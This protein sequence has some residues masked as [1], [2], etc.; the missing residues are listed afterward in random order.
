VE[1]FAALIKP[2]GAVL[3]FACGHGR[4][5]AYLAACGF[6]VDAV[7][8]DASALAPLSTLANVA[9]RCADLESGPWP[10]HGARFDGVI[11]TSYLYR[12]R[13]AELLALVAEEGVLIYETFMAGHEAFGKPSNPDFLLQPDELLDRV[14]GT[15]K[16]VAFEQGRI[17]ANG[18]MVIQRVCAVRGPVKDRALCA[19]ET[20]Q[21]AS[22]LS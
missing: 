6:A 3:D 10:Y 2:G 4:H 13:F 19:R 5:A 15:L 7:D 22:V 14:R 8:R 1:R 16:V 11:V 9:T 17:E 18:S 12:P 21:R 20:D